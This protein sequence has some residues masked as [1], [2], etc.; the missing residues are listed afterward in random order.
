M[1]LQPIPHVIKPYS[2]N[3]TK[4]PEDGDQG[5]KV[6][7]P[8]PPVCEND[9]GVDTFKKTA[10]SEMPKTPAEV[11]AEPK[12]VELGEEANKNPFSEGQPPVQKS[13]GSFF[14]G[15]GRGLKKGWNAIVNFFTKDV[16]AVANNIIAGTS[17]IFRNVWNKI[18]QWWG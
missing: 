13:I 8:K 3:Q 12:V 9:N 14:R 17:S 1:D 18:V 2:G 5:N 16:P 11:S 7:P 4:K 15:I 10:A 6:V